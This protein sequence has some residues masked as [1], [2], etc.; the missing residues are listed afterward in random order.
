MDVL[1]AHPFEIRPL[2]EDDGGGFLVSF[3]DFAE[4]MGRH[5]LG[6]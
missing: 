3:P 5:A 4:A 1:H 6:S 2:S